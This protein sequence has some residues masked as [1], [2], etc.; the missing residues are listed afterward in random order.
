MDEIAEGDVVEAGAEDD[1]DEGR[2]DTTFVKVGAVCI[3]RSKEIKRSV[4]RFI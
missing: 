1:A 4:T 3:F 2:V